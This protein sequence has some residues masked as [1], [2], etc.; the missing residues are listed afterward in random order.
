MRIFPRVNSFVSIL[1]VFIIAVAVLSF[2]CMANKPERKQQV[3]TEEHRATLSAEDVIGALK[4]GNQNFA[5]GDWTD[6]DFRHQQMKTASGQY[7]GAVVLS[8]IDSRAPAE[9]ILN[10]GIG[11]IFNA[12][13]AGNVLNSDIT[14]SME[15]ACAAA[16][17]KVILVMGHTSCGAVKGAIDKVEMGNLTGLL[18]KIKPAMDAVGD[19]AGERS[20]KNRAYVDA[21]TKMN[22]LLAVDEIRNTSPILKKMEEDGTIKIVGAMYDLD[23]GKVEFYDQ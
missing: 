9:I 10:Q 17:S 7:P 12:R 19:S 22:V 23:T 13:V 1:T 14:G 15:F 16:G 5:G 11:D 2:G 18:A 3:M 21:V 4:E 20:S 8:C 6:W